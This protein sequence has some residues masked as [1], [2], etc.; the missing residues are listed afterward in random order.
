M[1]RAQD[2]KQ[3]FLSVDKKIA[4]NSDGDYFRVGDI[5]HHEGAPEAETANILSF[6]ID[7]ESEE[8]LVYTS[9]GTC[10]LDFIYI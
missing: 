8:V 3:N 9:R 1:E 10:H 2:L 7:I 5:V 6:D 4:M